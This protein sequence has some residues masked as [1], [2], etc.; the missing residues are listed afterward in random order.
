MAEY[1]I[2]YKDRNNKIKTV[3]SF[4]PSIEEA[5]ASGS[6]PSGS[7]FQSIDRKDSYAPTTV[8]LV[9]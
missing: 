5:K 9:R 3:Q 8:V 4:A 2:T 1:I 6:L 7:K